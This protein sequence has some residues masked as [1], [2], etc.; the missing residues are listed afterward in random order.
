MLN[1]VRV[2][3]IVCYQGGRYRD[4]AGLRLDGNVPE[5]GSLVLSLAVAI[6]VVIVIGCVVVVG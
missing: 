5:E 2:G 1:F 3:G 6:P 4:V